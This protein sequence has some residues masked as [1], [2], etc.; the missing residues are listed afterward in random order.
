MRK[1][2]LLLFAFV[3]CSLSFLKANLYVVTNTLGIITAGSLPNAINQANVSPGPDTIVF[4]IGSG[5]QTI[6]PAAKLSINDIVFIDGTTQPGFSGVTFDPIIQIDGDLLCCGEPI[7]ELVGG[8][9][10]SKIKGLI[11]IDNANNGLDLSVNNVVVRGCWF[12]LDS[13]G[14]TFDPLLTG[15]QINTGSKNDTI[16]GSLP[17]D[18][19]IISGNLGNGITILGDSNV[20]MGSYVGTTKTG[21][22]AAPNSTGIIIQA[23]KYNY[24]GNP[25]A[26]NFISG[27]TNQG[28]QIQNGARENHVQNNLIGMKAT[29]TDSLPNDEGIG[30]AFA[31]YNYIG[32]AGANEGN[33]LS[34]NNFGLHIHNNSDSNIVFGNFIGVTPMDGVVKNLLNG[35]LVS[36]SQHT[37]IGGPNAG[38]RNVISANGNANIGLNQANNTFISGNYI[39]TNIN[40]GNASSPLN[41]IGISVNNS[42]AITI[43]GNSAA[44]RN[45]IC[46]SLDGIFINNFSNNVLI[47]DNY[48]GVAFF[49]GN[50]IPNTNGVHIGN[51][52]NNTTIQN[53]T[54]SGNTAK[55]IFSEY[56]TS[57]LVTIIGNY[58]GT[59]PTGMSAM[60][61]FSG[62]Y[63]YSKA[64]IGGSTVADRNIICANA[65][66]IAIR[67]D[68]CRVQGNY[69]GVDIAL[70][71]LGNTGEGIQVIQSDTYTLIGGFNP[72]EKNI[73]ANNNLAGIFV[74]DNF[75]TQTNCLIIGN[76]MYNN[77]TSWPGIDLT[78]GGGS[79]MGHNAND[80]G[81]VDSYGNRGQNYPEV[82]CLWMVPGGS[83]FNA[84]YTL[85]SEPSKK[86]YIEWFAD[87]IGQ[88]VYGQG[89]FLLSSNYVM[90]DGAGNFS[91]TAFFSFASLNGFALTCT[92]SD[93]LLKVT[94][95]FSETKI[96]LVLTLNGTS[97]IGCNG[98]T[99]QINCN[100]A[101]GGQ[102]PYVYDWTPGNPTGDGTAGILATAGAWMC[103]VTDATGCAAKIDSVTLGQPTPVVITPAS[104]TNVNCF[105]DSTGTASA[106]ISGGT[107]PFTYSW[108]PNPPIN[109]TTSASNLAAGT[110][111]FVVYE[112]TCNTQY[113]FT[114][115]QAPQISISLTPA[116]SSCGS[117]TGAVT[118]SVSG[119]TGGLNYYW[120]TA[121]TTTSISSLTA[122][123][124]FLQ[125]T[126]AN[127]CYASDAVVVNDANGPTITMNAITPV[128][129]FGLSDGA[130]DVGISGGA[131]PYTIL[132]SD[133]E[134]TEDIS[135]LSSGSYDINVIDN[136]GCQSSLTVNV[137]QPDSFSFF[138]AL[139]APSICAANDGS[140]TAFVTGGTGAVTFLWDANAANQTTGTAN[141][142]AAGSYELVITDANGC[143]DSTM[144]S[145]SDPGSPF[146]VI[147]SFLNAGCILT[148][149]N[150]AIFT[151][152]SGTGPF[153]YSWTNGATTQDIS[154]I[155]IGYFGLTVTDL[156]SNC[157]AAIDKYIRGERPGTAQICMLTVDTATNN[158]VL[159]W[160]DS[161]TGIAEYKIYRETSVAGNYNLISIIPAGTANT[162]IDTLANPDQKPWRY[163]IK[164]TDSCGRTSVYSLAHKTIHCVVNPNATVGFD[165]FWDQYQGP[166]VAFTHYR[167]FRD[168]FSTGWVLV[169][170]VPAAGPLYYNDVTSPNQNDTNYYFIEINADINCS[171]TRAL[172]N[173]SRSNIRNMA[174]P[175]GTLQ[176]NEQQ[177]F[178]FSVY[179][180]PSKNTFNLNFVT[181]GNYN[182]QVFDA[183]GRLVENEKFV[184][185][186]NSVQQLNSENWA[187]GIYTLRVICPDG[188]A[189][190][191]KLIKQ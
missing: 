95:E 50:T 102:A 83:Q 157:T 16:G 10:N 39:G 35:I 144:Y 138:S 89:K 70:N 186:A 93:S 160:N 172:V 148:G 142:L 141:A 130:I 12:G 1:I 17:G 174:A 104:Q 111:T 187:S 64:I 164:T 169:D 147:D 37:I 33:T 6:H 126:D 139:T 113:T 98:G 150:G 105:G 29:I 13:S 67:S 123:N 36:Q 137:T 112:A 106:N 91:D 161:V 165:V 155:G 60:G 97:A 86:Y 146:V 56:T 181:G 66:G 81:D 153:S 168:H 101:T 108:Y 32:G 140:I 8:S 57:G 152:E 28:I 118:S 23:G 135:G 129:C 171:S 43:G 77:N 185:S 46:N 179:P 99:G 51:D 103:T 109:T 3:L 7:M 162:Y 20:I 34:G 40:A 26:G 96:P 65:N 177:Q 24:I 62:I 143:M 48:I 11:F 166:T 27:N 133:N 119:G 52:C 74:M 54:I 72:A 189:K 4:N 94:S 68:S 188:A 178:L 107:G 80:L 61:N 100:P 41:N 49:G 115:T 136:G 127:N 5:I 184:V 45:Y 90:T 180:N 21:N 92:A 124:Y 163:E 173:T 22:S 14:F 18:R 191:I 38:E 182:V 167:I 156:S 131:L 9:A 190:Q 82:N 84:T 30:M 116:P 63:T 158:N 47:K 149:G 31:N 132:W 59:E 25:T 87:P 42:S 69:I 120:N 73:I 154:G 19:C 85:N 110:Y 159:V 55:G 183:R 15:I 128:S 79:T 78:T 117:S 76:E 44:D 145:I 170:S 122:G 2:Q 88:S 125:I 151:S 58:I 114:I 75:P 134:T 175:S 53:N 121:A 71:P 176:I